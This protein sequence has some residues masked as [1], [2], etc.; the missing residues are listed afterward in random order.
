MPCLPPRGG[1]TFTVVRI[2][3]AVTLLLLVSAP[4]YV[5][6]ERDYAGPSGLKELKRAYVDAAFHKEYRKADGLK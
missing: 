2:P 6:R 1:L 5:A 4:A 3:T